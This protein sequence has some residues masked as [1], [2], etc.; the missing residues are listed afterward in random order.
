MVDLIRSDHFPILFLFLNLGGCRGRVLIVVVPVSTTNKTD[1]HD[2]TEILL[3]A[4]LTTITLT[5][6]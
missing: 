2:K 4:A 5:L 1:R 6:N 3:N